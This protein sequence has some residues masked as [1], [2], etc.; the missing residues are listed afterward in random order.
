MS[1]EQNPKLGIAR[2]DVRDQFRSVE[3]GRAAHVA[4]GRWLTVRYNMRVTLEI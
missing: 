1:G 4:G 2:F 3:S